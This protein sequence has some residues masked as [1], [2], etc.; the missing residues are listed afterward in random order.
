MVFVPAHRRLAIL[1]SHVCSASD[2][3]LDASE[4][5]PVDVLIVG[6]GFAGLYMLH[7]LRNAGFR[8]RVLEAGAG[9]GGTWYWNRY[10]GC[11]CDVPSVEYSYGFSEELQQ[12]WSWTE[13]MAS[14]PEILRYANHVADRFD[15][16]GDIMFE[17]RVVEASYDDDRQRWR[18]TI[19]TGRVLEAQ[20]LV[21]ATGCLS[22]PNSPSIPGVEAF[23]G[24]VYHTGSWPHE[25]VDFAGKKVGIIG[26]GSSGTQAIPELAASCAHLTVFQR[27]PNYAMPANNGPLTEEVTRRVK[28][29]YSEL[30]SMQRS[31]W[32]GW[33]LAG[34]GFGGTEPRKDPRYLKSLKAQAPEE[35]LAA[36]EKLGFAAIREYN[37]VDIDTEANE[38]ACELYRSQVK[39]IVH[40]PKV[41]R[42]LMP[43]NYPLGC[44]RPV[45]HTGYFETFNRDNVTLVDLRQGGIR[46]VVA[47]GVDTDQGLFDVD[48]LVLATGFDA[49]TGPLLRLGVRGRGGLPLQQHWASGP[50]TH[51]GLQVSG[52]PNLFTITG[53]GSPSV[54]SNMIMSI[55]QHVDWIADAMTHMRSKGLRTMEATPEAEDAWVRRVNETAAFTMFTAPSCNSWYLGANIPGKPRMFMPYVGGFPKYRAHCDRAAANGYEGF[56]LR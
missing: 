30:R 45:M 43:L 56:A 40:D 11:R 19:D 10:P 6:A 17:M 20:F 50:R 8:A 54:L 41:A 25:G 26:T 14:Q 18:V 13:V 38:I 53:P 5:N 27:T 9:V 28:A 12:D 52:F 22:A 49:M 48:A 39:R 21:A 34:F 29:S 44:K 24:P 37:D 51:L 4:A 23:S 31:S 7:R 2:A 46:Q 32:G 33:G 55:E 1:T 16:R 47:G 36:F 42:A 35:R 3:G 15:L